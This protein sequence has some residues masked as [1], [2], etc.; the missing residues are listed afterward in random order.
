MARSRSGACASDYAGR[1]PGAPRTPPYGHQDPCAGSLLDH[2]G[3]HVS[4]PDRKRGPRCVRPGLTKRPWWSAERRAGR[5]HRPVIPS[6]EGMGPIARR[7]MG[8]AVFRTSAFR[9]SAPLML[10]GAAKKKKRRMIRATP[11]RGNG[12]RRACKSAIRRTRIH[13]RDD[14]DGLRRFHHPRAPCRRSAS[15]SASRAPPAASSSR[16]R[17]RQADRRW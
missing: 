10:R 2:P 13:Q 1:A 14:S 7:A 8:A 9:R 16:C 6:D 5:R 15:R 4:S 17:D 12:R 11:R 3:E